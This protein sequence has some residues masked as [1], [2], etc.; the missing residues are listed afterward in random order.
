MRA[1]TASCP[2]LRVICVRPF[3]TTLVRN[4][5]DRGFPRTPMTSSHPWQPDFVETYRRKCR[6]MREVVDLLRPDDVVAAPIAGGQPAGFLTTL[7]ERDDWRDFTL[8]SGL[9][10]APY[11][12][13]TNPN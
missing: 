12:V 2:T 11:A 5:E 10:I 7:A 6:S 8:F 13:L 4:D 1:S 9:L 3:H